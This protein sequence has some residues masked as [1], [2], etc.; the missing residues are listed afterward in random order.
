MWAI[1]V[2]ACVLSLEHWRAGPKEI[3]RLNVGQ[4]C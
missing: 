4:I 2:E 3:Q 1:L